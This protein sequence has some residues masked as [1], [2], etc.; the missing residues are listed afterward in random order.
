M[1]FSQEHYF[2]QCPVAFGQPD[3]YGRDSPCNIQHFIY[4]Q[5]YVAQLEYSFQLLI[6]FIG[7]EADAH[8]SLYTFRSEVK[9]G[10]HFKGAFCHPIGTLNDPKTVVLLINLIGREVRIGDISF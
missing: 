7:H 10:T 5:A 4:T 3:F 9:H 8:V 2:G 6:H 1:L